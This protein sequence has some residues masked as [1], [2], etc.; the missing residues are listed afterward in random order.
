MNYI[1]TAINYFNANEF[2]KAEQI[3][4]D[5]IYKNIFND[6]AIDI[7]AAV[8][9]RTNKSK[10]LETASR[11]NLDIIR[12]TAVFL[13]KLKM[14]DYSMAFYKK[15]LEI[16]PNDHVGLNNMGLIYENLKDDEKAKM[17]YEKS[18]KVKPNYEAFYNLG[19]YY[20]KQ[21]D[22]DNAIK[23]VKEALIFRPNNPQTEYSLGM[24]YFMDSDFENGYRHFLKRETKG[25]DGLKNFWNGEMHTDKTILVF[26]DYGFGDAIMYS[27]YFPFLKNYFKNIKVCCSKNLKH[28]FEQSFDNI[29][30]Y[31]NCLTEYD[32]CVLAMNLPYFLNMDFS[33]IPFS[34]GYLKAEENKVKKYKELY[35]NTNK[36]KIGLFWVGGG[37]DK[38]TEKARRIN[39][40]E[41]QSLFNISQAQFYSFQVEDPYDE[42]KDFPQIKNLGA[43]F[44]DFSDTASAMKNLDLMISID[45]SAIHL[46]GG[47]GVKSYLMLPKCSEWRWFKNEKKTL[48]YNSVELFTQKHLY[49]WSDVVNEIGNKIKSF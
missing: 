40:F 14:Y 2:E 22:T 18:L 38:R 41:L 32:Y 10:L 13:N 48:W 6:D 12:K 30:F 3:A 44:Y 25:I 49:N 45:S 11:K 28:L 5:C 46:A 20:R 34:E 39:L 17:C 33:K 16:E 29:D 27:R 47:L 8:Y 9:L 42:I 37:R 36:L 26:C 1:E 4:L 15:A 24:L 43:T 21:K 7:I 31:T 35:F 23:Y 19:I